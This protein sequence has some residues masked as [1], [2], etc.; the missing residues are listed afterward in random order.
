M[1]GCGLLVQGYARPCISPNGSPLC[2]LALNEGHSPGM[3]RILKC[4]GRADGV[5]HLHPEAHAFDIGVYFEAN[6]H[7]TALFSPSLIQ[8][9][10][11]WWCNPRCADTIKLRDSLATDIPME[12]SHVPLIL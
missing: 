3:R 12:L 7:G 1:C 8:Q 4:C 2:T 11:Q 10:E 6:G 5:K 9:L